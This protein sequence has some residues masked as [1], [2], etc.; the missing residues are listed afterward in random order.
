MKILLINSYF[1]LIGG[2]EV[3]AYN[4]YKILKKHGHDVYF[5]ATDYKPYIEENYEYKE[6]FTEYTGGTKNYLKNPIRYFYN[7]QAKR[8]LQRFISLI[9]PD[10]IHIH[11]L[12]MVTYSIL[13]LCKKIPTI[14][15]AH[16]ANFFCPA[17]SFMLNDKTLCKDQLCKNNNYL[18]CIF[19]KCAK[20]K[21]EPSIRRAL[22]YYI[23]NRNLDNIDKFITPSTA[24]KD[25]V[26]KANIGINSDSVYVINNFLTDGELESNP[27]YT[28][29]GYFLYAGRLDI[30][31]GVH[32]LL[33]A[34]KDLPQNI[35]L[36]IA[37]KG[38]EEEKL[39]QY[40]NDNNMYN[41]HF[42]GY[43]DRENLKN[44]Y[45]N[46]IAS[47]LP[48]NCFESFGMTSIEAFANGKPVIASNIGGIP[49]IVEQE[50][51]GLLFEPTNVEELKQ[52]ILKYWNNP[53]L[54]IEHGQN[55]YNKVL[56]KYTEKVY[57]EKLVDLYQEVLNG[58]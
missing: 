7:N 29:N 36:H 50:K 15:T 58:K 4:T 8:D 20:G 37:G 54:V 52:C 39:K 40:A 42:L 9:Q 28:N 49:E 3:I 44:E 19:N 24:L 1:S 23:K 27:N 16:G 11:T 41:I 14:Y 57:Y 25:A 48:S 12:D 2:A 55:G 53:N 6:Y 35:E 18:P 56:E 30:T 22:M 17:A 45:Q 34:M 32:Y 46:C 10:I 5:W 47:I 26:I 13:E 51:T 33:S 31:K 21:L 43:M 38:T